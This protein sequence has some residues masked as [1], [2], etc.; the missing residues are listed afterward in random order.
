MITRFT[1]PPITLLVKG[2]NI[3][4]YDIYVTVKQDDNEITVS[5]GLSV[6]LEGRDTKI[7]FQLTQEQAGSLDFRGFAGVQVNWIAD[8]NRYATEI[9]R[10]QI[11]NNLFDEVIE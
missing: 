1:T 10:V 4:A 9:A 6:S 3:T 7:V 11:Y 8:G 2:V 5:D